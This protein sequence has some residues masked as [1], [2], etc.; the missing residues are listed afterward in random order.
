MY[1]SQATGGGLRR[2]VSTAAA[3]G[4]PDDGG[5]GDEASEPEEEEEA[6]DVE[7]GEAW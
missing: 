6:Q 1:T 4:V 7:D 5:D 2:R 3:E